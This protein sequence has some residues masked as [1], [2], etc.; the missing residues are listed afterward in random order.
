MSRIINSHHV[1]QKIKTVIYSVGLVLALQDIE[2]TTITF[3][4]TWR[5]IVYTVKVERFVRKQFHYLRTCGL[6]CQRE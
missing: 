1:S 4:L 3:E 5:C 6:S 2:Q